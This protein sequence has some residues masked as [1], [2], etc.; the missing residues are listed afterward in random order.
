MFRANIELAD[1][2]LESAEDMIAADIAPNAKN[3]TQSGVKYC[4]T[5][6][7][8]MLVSFGVIGIGPS[9]LVWFQS[10]DQYKFLNIFNVYIRVYI[11]TYTLIL[12]ILIII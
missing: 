3:A 5:I 11:Y 2:T 7:N 4:I 10:I 1:K 12:S 9:Y 6:G 8:T